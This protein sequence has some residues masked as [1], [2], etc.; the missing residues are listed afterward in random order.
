MSYAT[1]NNAE[2]CA[3]SDD[4]VEKVSPDAQSNT[5]MDLCAISPSVNPKV[6]DQPTTAHTDVTPTIDS[7]QVGYITHV[8]FFILWNE[9]VRIIEYQN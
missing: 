8:K 3:I 6:I 5:R 2:S 4:N 7:S 1:L 9:R